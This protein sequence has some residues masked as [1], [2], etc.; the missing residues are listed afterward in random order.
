MIKRQTKISARFS[1]KIF[2]CLILFSISWSKIFCQSEVLENIKNAFDKYHKDLN[3]KIF[4]HTDKSFYVAGEIVWFKLYNVDANVNVLLNVSKVA[5]VEIIGKDQKPVLQ[6]KVLLKNGLG[7]GSFYLPFTV[8]SGNFKLRAYTSWMKNFSADYFFEKDITIINTVKKL[9]LKPRIDSVDYD[10][11]F[12]P[13]GGN[14]VNGI[15]SKVAFRMVD[16]FGRGVDFDGVLINQH[17]DTVSRFHPLK[18]GIGTFRFTPSDSNQYKAIVKIPDGKIVNAGLPKIFNSGYV[19][20]V[21]DTTNNRLFITVSARNVAENPANFL[22][23]HCKQQIQVAQMENVRDN[24]TAF[25]INKDSLGE[26]VSYLTIFDARRQPVCERLYFKRPAQQL[27]IEAKTEKQN[28]EL[29]K[30]ISIDIA[31]ADKS[32]NA[33]PANLSISVYKRDSLQQI[34]ENNILTYLWLTSNLSGNIESPAYYLKASDSFVDEATD[35]LMLTHGWRRFRWEEAFQN[36][37][38]SFE[39]APEYEGH[40][41]VGKV[42]DKNSGRAGIDIATYLAVPAKNYQLASSVSDAQGVVK[43]DI[44]DFFSTDGITIQTAELKDTNYSIDILNP[45]SEK[46]SADKIPEFDPGNNNEKLLLHHSVNTQVQNVYSAAGLQTFDA[47]QTKDTTAFYGKPDQKYYLDDYTRFNTMEEVMRE[48]IA[49]ITVRKHD[50]H[51]HYKVLNYPYK[52]F[53]ESDPLVLFDGVPATDIN[54]IMAFD[55]LKIRKIEVM[56]RR[57]FLGP[58]VADGIISYSTYNG[59]LAGFQF[60]PNVLVL[61]YDGLQL[62]REFYSPVYETQDQLDSR[63]PDFRN[64]LYW[65]PNVNTNDTGKKQISFYTSDLKGKYIGVIQGITADGKAGVQTFSFAVGN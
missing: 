64:V 14:L 22:I 39:F 16:R 8:A 19:M 27:M 11:Q 29:R 18:F 47:F 9:G 60:D 57:Y 62:Q 32:G 30:R 15:E 48:Y 51:F 53:F 55:P 40:I 24:K 10:L 34:D 33:I 6:A 49:D 2:C 1:R 31:S 17:N 28:F 38:P 26:G 45:F 46:I 43:F 59:D 20:T 23:I 3:E 52:L 12:F 50:G 42:I 56:N 37:T 58:L 63:L 54:K 4:V 21:T 65:S 5:Y 44:K 13:E 25:T 35:N 61:K 41:I 7:S 36:K